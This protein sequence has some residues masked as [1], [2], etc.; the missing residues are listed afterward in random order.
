MFRKL[1]NLQ[2]KRSKL[3][4]IC[5]AFSIGLGISS[6]TFL[7]TGCE[8]VQLHPLLLQN[9]SLKDVAL[10]WR[11]ERTAQSG[12]YEVS[13]QTDLPNR[14]Q[15]TVA[16]LRYLYPITAKARSFSKPTYAILDYQT[17]TVEQGAWQTQLNLWQVAPDQSFKENWQIDQQGLATQF[18]PEA[19]VVFLVTLAP[20][21]Q[22]VR[23]QQRLANHGEKLASGM[24]RSTS[25]GELYAQSHQ[26]LPV[27]L[28][29]GS[30]VS[31][32]FRPGIGNYG[33]GSRYLIPYEPQNPTQLERPS[34]RQTN[35]PAR[36][37]EFLR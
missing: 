11:V 9:K 7:L 37:E 12:T 35:S 19:D 14:T 31:T 24:V 6:S 1:L 27:A 22:L 17:V 36:P 10:K 21:D 2:Q 3:S 28:P 29:T 34:E 33:W 32:A 13:G 18:Q 8:Q 23:L 16:A 15:L 20:I 30:T 4:S 26:I 5:C 25:E